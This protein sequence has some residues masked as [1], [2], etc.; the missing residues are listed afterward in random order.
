MT[1]GP[2]SPSCEPAERMAR[3]RAMRAMAL[4]LARPHA[5]FIRALELGESNP[6]SLS[7]ALAL[8]EQL[9][10]LTRR[11]LLAS[12]ARLARPIR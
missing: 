11:R 6:T 3:L 7:E 4:L 9:P 12:Y 10:A 2:W 1:F 8:L 5:S